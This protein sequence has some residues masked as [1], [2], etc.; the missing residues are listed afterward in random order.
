MNMILSIKPSGNGRVVTRQL[1]NPTLEEMALI[2]RVNKYYLN[3]DIN[4]WQ[5][6]NVLTSK[7]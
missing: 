6:H 3:S 7:L 2:K 1:S 5:R 4:I